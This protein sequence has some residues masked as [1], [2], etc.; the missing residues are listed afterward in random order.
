MAIT[1]ENQRL[2]R[3]SSSEKELFVKIDDSAL[4]VAQNIS[5]LLI[6]LRIFPL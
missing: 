2:T 3:K 6:V 5:Y 1:D 4:T